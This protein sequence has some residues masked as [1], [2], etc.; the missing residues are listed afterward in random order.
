MATSAS[1]ITCSGCERAVASA[2]PT[3]APMN[4]SRPP[5]ANGA[6]RLCSTRWATIVASRVSHTS[7]SSSVNSSPES[8]ATVSLGRSGGLE[9]VRDG[10][11]QLVAGRVPQRIVDELEAVEVEEQDRRAAFGMVAQ[12]AADRLVEAIDEQHPVG[13][14]GQRVVQRIVLQAA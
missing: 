8:R 14:A 4:T 7:S 11:E 3:D 5:S 12:G 1:R 6:C 10:R 9:P 2:I 13:Q